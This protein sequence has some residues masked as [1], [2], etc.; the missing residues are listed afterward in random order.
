MPERPLNVAVIGSGIAGM[1][2]AV[3]IPLG[4]A[5]HA[6]R[7]VLRSSQVGAIAALH[8]AR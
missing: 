5:F 7:L 8:R 6:R 1:A 3:E 2:A 4:E